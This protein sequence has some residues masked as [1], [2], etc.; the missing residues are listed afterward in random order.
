MSFPTQRLTI[1]PEEYRLL[2]PGLDVMA[3]GLASAK[4]GA[5][6]HRHPYH[7]I[8]YV[9]TDIYRGLR[10]KLWE[11]SQSRKIRLDDQAY[12]DEGGKSLSLCRI[13]DFR[14]FPK[15]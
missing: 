12:D 11:L 4:L 6:P 3:N 7:R 15:V 13:S 8:D 2:G 1:T 10:E 9:A 14:N 5:F